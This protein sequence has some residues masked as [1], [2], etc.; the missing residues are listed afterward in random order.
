MWKPYFSGEKK[1]C[2]KTLFFRREKKMSKTLF[3]RREKKMSK[4][5]IFQERKKMS[6]NP[7][8][9]NFHSQIH[10][11]KNSKNFY[12]QI[13]CKKNSKNFGREKYGKNFW[14]WKKKFWSLFSVEKKSVHFENFLSWNIKY[15]FF[16]HEKIFGRKILSIW[17][18][19]MYKKKS[20]F[21]RVFANFLAFFTQ[22][23]KKNFFF[24]GPK[25]LKKPAKNLPSD[26]RI[27]TSQAFLFSNWKQNIS[28]VF[29]KKF[30]SRT[31][32]NGPRTILRSFLESTHCQKNFFLWSLK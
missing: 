32:T 2:E 28:L 18:N 31:L 19:L 10:C 6:K 26:Q 24:R 17:K 30:L 22:K 1:K 21:P 15:F 7:I 3:F 20:F 8:K 16:V 4:N 25:I 11:K 27:T 23:K 9:K 14:P 13:H 29:R 12:S 5:P